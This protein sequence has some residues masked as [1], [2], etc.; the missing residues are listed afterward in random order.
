[1]SSLLRIPCPKCSKIYKTQLYDG[2]EKI[3]CSKCANSF[4]VSVKDGKIEGGRRNIWLLTTAIFSCLSA[5]AL[6]CWG[7]ILLVY[8]DETPNIY[9]AFMVIEVAISF[10]AVIYATIHSLERHIFQ[11]LLL[12]DNKSETAGV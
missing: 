4:E 10:I 1:M 8:G 12:L 2:I 5:F 11:P 7:F 6:M 3:V 9:F